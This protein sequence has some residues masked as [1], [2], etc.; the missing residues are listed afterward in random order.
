MR[1]F[2][3]VMI[4]PLS[5]LARCPFLLNTNMTTLSVITVMLLMLLMSKI[6]ILEGCKPAE[7]T[8]QSV[9]ERDSDVLECYCFELGYASGNFDDALVCMSVDKLEG[10]RGQDWRSVGHRWHSYN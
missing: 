10:D 4:S 9:L 6:L 7:D 5:L 2:S 8:L 1:Y 3:S